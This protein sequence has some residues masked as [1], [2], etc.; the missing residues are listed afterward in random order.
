MAQCQEIFKS[1]SN[2]LEWFKKTF[3]DTFFS[4]GLKRCVLVQK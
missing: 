3:F 4:R 2:A 1:Q